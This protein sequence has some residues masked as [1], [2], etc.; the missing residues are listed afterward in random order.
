[1]GRPL[2][3]A[4]RKSPKILLAFRAPN[5][6]LHLTAKEPDDCN[7]VAIIMSSKLLGSWVGRDGLTG[8]RGR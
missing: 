4:A 8:L 5:I 6:A 2:D 7:K 3:L 1:M